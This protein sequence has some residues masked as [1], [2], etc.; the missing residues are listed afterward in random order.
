MERASQRHPRTMKRRVLVLNDT[1]R[2]GA[3]VGCHTVM[4]NILHLCAH[5]G[6]E[7]VGTIETTDAL[8]SAKFHEGLVSADIVLVNGE[9]TMH[10]DAPAALALAR[11]VRHARKAGRK[12]ALINSVWQ[13]NKEL[14]ASLA[15]FDHVAVRDSLSLAE[16]K[17]AGAADALFAPEYSLLA[18]ADA[19]DVPTRSRVGH[20]TPCLVTDSVLQ[21]VSE[22]LYNYAAAQKLPFRYMVTW[23]W[24]P[25]M[26]RH[27]ISRSGSLTLAELRA[28]PLVIAGRFHAVCL[29]MRYG[30]PFL[31]L[32]SNTH[33]VEALL[34]DA[35]LPEADFLLPPEWEQRECAYWI[36]RSRRNWEKYQPTVAAYVTRASDQI[37]EA[38]GRFVE[39]CARA[40][41]LAVKVG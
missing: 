3:H 27:P 6:L 40:P 16:C 12:T 25:E 26:G 24:Q 30:V 2:A 32:P 18:R 13:H 5:N 21:P 34:R 37:H 14:N 10:H 28:A 22:R 8:D 19:P 29:A 7:V 41:E 38:F 11:A 36:E 33:K 35:G 15:D 17:A 9:G 31:A 20:V 23:F 4:S 39:T 1:R